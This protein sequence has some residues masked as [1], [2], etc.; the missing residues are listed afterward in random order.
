MAIRNRTLPVLTG[1]T[2]KKKNVFTKSNNHNKFILKMVYYGFTLL[3]RADQIR[4]IS[5]N[6]S[7]ALIFYA[8]VA[9]VAFVIFYSVNY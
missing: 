4:S 1:L 8:A 3:I 9:V 5:D 6:R 2:K 7:A